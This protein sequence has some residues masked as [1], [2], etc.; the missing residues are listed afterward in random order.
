MNDRIVEFQ[1]RVLERPGIGNETHLPVEMALLPWDNLTCPRV[2]S[3]ASTSLGWACSAG[4]LPIS[5]AQDLLKVPNNFLALVLSMESV[6]SNIYQGEGVPIKINSASS[7]GSTENKPV[8]TR[9]IGSTILK[10]TTVH[11]VVRKRIWPPARKRG[12]HIPNF[13]KTLEHFC[14]HAGGKAML[15]AI[16]DKLKLTDRNIEAL[17]MT[18]LGLETPHLHQPG[19][20]SATVLFGSAFKSSNLVIPVPDQTGSSST[21]FR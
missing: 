14:I 6:S 8:I 9:H 5:L 12:P 10:P 1:S 16:T 15:D 4:I 11:S 20:H 19:I 17:E 18:T 7:R 21:Q 13:K 2:T 3:R